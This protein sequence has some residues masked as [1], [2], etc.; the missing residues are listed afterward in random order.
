[1]EG[2]AGITDLAG[3]A[4]LEL[5]EED[6]AEREKEKALERGVWRKCVCSLL[7]EPVAWER[8]VK[9]NILPLQNAFYCWTKSKHAKVGRR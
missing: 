5:D 3:E 8:I 9:H 6:G 2:G 4:K 7:L 1:V